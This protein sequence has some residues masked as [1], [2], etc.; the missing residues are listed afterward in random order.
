MRSHIANSHILPQHG[1]FDR[2]I[3][4]YATFE[5]KLNVFEVNFGFIGFI[6]GSMIATFQLDIFERLDVPQGTPF[7]RF[8]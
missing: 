4:K 3:I 2:N 1:N 5:L 8:Y 7:Q 6:D